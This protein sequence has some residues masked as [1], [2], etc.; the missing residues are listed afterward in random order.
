MD[1]YSLPEPQL[2]ATDIGISIDEIFSR[3]K[4]TKRPTI[5]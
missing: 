4:I 1:I 5:E 3:S 2:K